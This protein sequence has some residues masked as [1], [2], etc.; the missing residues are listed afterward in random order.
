MPHSVTTVLLLFRRAL[1][2][3]ET[4]VLKRTEY[5]EMTRLPF[6]NPLGVSCGLLSL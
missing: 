6:W 1:Y 2:M 5:L 3:N 4:Y